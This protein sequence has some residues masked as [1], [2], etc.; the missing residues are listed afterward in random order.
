MS[1][2]DTLEKARKA[3]PKAKERLVA[4]ISISVMAVITV[5]WF[6]FTLSSFFK[7]GLPNNEAPQSHTAATSTGIAPPFTE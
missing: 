1:L 2:L 6:L 3:P 4:I 7:N 5:I